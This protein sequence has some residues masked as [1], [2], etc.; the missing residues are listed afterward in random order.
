M[1]FTASEGIVC[2]YLIIFHFLFR[3]RLVVDRSPKML[4]AWSWW[5]GFSQLSGPLDHIFWHCLVGSCP[6]PAWLGAL[7]HSW[8]YHL[9]HET[10][11]REVWF[12]DYQS[13]IFAQRIAHLKQAGN[14][15][16][17]REEGWKTS[18]MGHSFYIFNNS[19]KNNGQANSEIAPILHNSYNICPFARPVHIVECRR[20]ARLQ[21]PK[22]GSLIFMLKVKNLSARD[23]HWQNSRNISVE[24]TAI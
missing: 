8:R 1:I 7:D 18:T 19:R 3:D 17:E 5:Q 15:F 4:K 20:R 16:S 6:A 24:S 11:H 14:F 2:I 13:I 22:S 23:L 9:T 21:V 12:Y 10:S